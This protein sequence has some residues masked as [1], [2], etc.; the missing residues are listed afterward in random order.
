[1]GVQEMLKEMSEPLQKSASV[2]NVYGEPITAHG[3][4]LVPVAKV[5]YGFGGGAGVR[6]KDGAETG[7]KEEGG[8]GGGGVAAAPVGVLEITETC[9]RFIPFDSRL[10]LVGALAVGMLAGML[11]AKKLKR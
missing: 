3:K 9:T 1:M 8:G 10:K 5:A 4:T 6:Q 7:G 2:K 11:I